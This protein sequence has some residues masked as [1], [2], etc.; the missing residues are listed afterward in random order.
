MQSILVTGG[1][2]FI[3]HHLV[4]RLLPDYR[5]VIIDN[6]STGKSSNIP[7]HRNAVFYKEDIRNKETITDIIKRERINTCI[8]LAAVASV[9]ESLADS[10]VMDVNI[11]GTAS[12]LEACS[13]GNVSRFIFASSAAVYGE[14][15]IQPVPEGCELKPISPYGESKVAGEKLVMS[16]QKSGKIP[17]AISLRFFNVYGE[18]QN[19]RYAGVI[20]KFA[21]RLTKGLPPI[22]YG[23][24]K[25]TRDFISV[26]DIVDAI[27][28]AVKSNL[29]G[30]FN[31][32]TGRAITINELAKEMTYIFRLNLAPIYRDAQSGEIIQSCAETRKSADNLKFAAT[33]ELKNGLRHYIS[34]MVSKAS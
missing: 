9:T 22:I 6:L 14:S 33:T 29:S 4:K 34:A 16:F 20:T 15:K 10:D 30:T 8:H 31:I 28:L 25:Q 27:V 2:G 19:P 12:V 7:K 5:I 1:A 26:I 32:G 18:G 3:G 21:E 24:G 17:H 13:K 23:D 11:N